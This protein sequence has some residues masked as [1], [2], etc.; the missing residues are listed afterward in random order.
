MVTNRIR[1]ERAL[2]GAVLADP[3]AGH[4]VLDIVQASDFERPWHAQVLAAMRRL[5]SRQALADA[6]AVYQEIQYDPDLPRTTARDGVLLANL[7][8]SSPR[9]AHVGA[10]AAM[11][12]ESGI[13]HQVGLAGAQLAAASR[14]GELETALSQVS[15]T[16]QVIEACKARWNAVPGD[17][18]AQLP[19]VPRGWPSLAERGIARSGGTAAAESALMPGEVGDTSASRQPALAMTEPVAA[20]DVRQEMPG[21]TAGVRA[22]QDLAAGPSQ[23]GRVRGWLRPEHFAEP[24][25]GNLY[26]VMRDLHAC[27]QPVDP[28]TIA[29]EAQR[30]GIDCQPDMLRGGTAAFAV[31]S[32]REVYRLGALARIERAGIAI[33]AAAGDQARAPAGFLQLAAAQVNVLQPARAQDCRLNRAVPGP[34]SPLAAPRP[35]P[36]LGREAAQ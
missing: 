27:R 3:A 1:A 11:V 21:E 6:Y 14:S 16:G 13:R 24:Q 7:M 20:G 2:L 18:Q 28:L 8:E 12:I 23:L 31:S 33:Q 34:G 4:R 25:H 35:A 19:A 10:Y 22:L 30:R 5:K 32:A 29:W 26:A 15:R 17:V 9:S 36:R